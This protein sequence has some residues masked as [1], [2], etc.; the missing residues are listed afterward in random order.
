MSK[1][2]ITPHL[3]VE[4]SLCPAWIWH[5]LFTDPSLK[6]EIP[7][8]ALKLME[9]GVIHEEDYVKDLVF[10]EVKE[11][12]P[13]KA[14]AKTLEL[15]K[16]GSEL[17]YQGEIETEIDGFIWR[18]RPDLLQKIPGESNFGN[19]FYIPVDIKSSNEM[20][21]DHK[22]Q[23]AFYAE[24]LEKIQGRLPHQVA[25]INKEKQRRVIP[26][27]S[28]LM[29][30]MHTRANQILTILAG[31]KPTLHYRGGCKQSP[32]GQMC[33]QDCEAVN[34]AALVYNVRESTLDKLREAGFETVAELAELNPDKPQFKISA[35]TWKRIVLQAQ[36]LQKNDLIWL[37][38]PHIPTTPYPIY[39]DIEGDPLLGVDYLFG[40]WIGNNPDCHPQ[41]ACEAQQD[42]G[43][44]QEQKQKDINLPGF[45]NN[46]D[47]SERNIGSGMTK[48]CGQNDT[49]TMGQKGQFVYFL[50][51]QPEDE[52]QM[53]Q[54]FLAWLPTLPENYLVYH[55]APY[56]KI[57]LD[58]LEKKY[59]G[60][61]ELNKFRSKLIDLFEVVKNSVIFPL[62]FYSIKDLAKSRFVNYKW[63]HQKAGGAQSIF[64]YEKWLETGDEKVLQDILDYNED[65]VIATEHLL[66]WLQKSDV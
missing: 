57:H 42:W 65:D 34:D 20:N 56:E 15:M 38:E 61:P 40:F 53:W 5:D 18:G 46:S 22:F 52:K 6:G 4:Y 43:S 44:R 9:K 37:G 41:P 32:W 12:D 2:V 7:E 45:P 1:L 11:I 21:P 16:S 17:I 13:A 23:L 50:A 51:K 64:W 54:K 31:R 24:V 60:S 55:Y 28:E 35:D 36:S 33:L 63:R 66:N 49:K 58:L 19:W 62:Y 59:G 48:E 3:F 30:K 10:D 25:I 8:L 29:E 39:F 26:V 27:D 14:L 47:L